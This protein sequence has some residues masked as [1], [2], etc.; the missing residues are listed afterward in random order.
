MGGD[1]FVP[2]CTMSLQPAR[3]PATVMPKPDQDTN[4]GNLAMVGLEVGIGVGLGYLV[5]HWLDNKYGW[6]SRGA[7][8]GAMLGLAGGLYL[9]IKQAIS[10]NKD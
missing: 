2:F 6:Q 5:G 1:R 8:T 9:L 10:A 7:V 4:W 3:T